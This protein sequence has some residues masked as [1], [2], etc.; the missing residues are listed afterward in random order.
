M[1][2]FTSTHCPTANAGADHERW[3][4]STGVGTPEDV[5]GPLLFL[6]SDAATMTASILSRDLAYSADDE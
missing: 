1:T 2:V 6:L 3:R 4:A 5:A